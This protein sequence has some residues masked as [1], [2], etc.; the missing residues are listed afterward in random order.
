MRDSPGWQITDA[1]RA[2][3][4]EMEAAPIEVQKAEA[5]EIPDI[6]PAAATPKLD[7]VYS[8]RRIDKPR[9]EARLARVFERR[10]LRAR[11]G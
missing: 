9:S 10:R 8:A 7:V 5:I 6:V 2:A 11:S 4:R 3:L 1:G